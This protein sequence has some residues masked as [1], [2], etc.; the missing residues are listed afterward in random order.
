MS[1]DF[2]KFRK[3]Y[4]KNKYEGN[5]GENDVLPMIEEYFKVKLTKLDN[6][7]IMDFRDNYGIYYEVKT[8]NNN[9]T[10]HPTTMIGYNKVQFANR[11]GR[12]VYFIFNFFDGVYFYKYTFDKIKDFEIKRGGRCDRGKE[13][14]K[15]YCYIPIEKLTKLELEETDITGLSIP[16][17]SI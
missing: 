2:I 15:I 6:N 11:L 12:P 3:I 4:L 16:L 1:K 5:V 10:T 13:E 8:R 17:D 14:Y 7:N 9:Y